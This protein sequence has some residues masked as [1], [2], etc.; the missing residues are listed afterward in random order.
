VSSILILSTISLATTGLP[1]P[2]C[3]LPA[4]E[5]AFGDTVPTTTTPF[6][7]DW[8]FWAFF[9][10]AIAIVLSQMP[11]I[12]QWFRGP[13]LIVEAPDQMRISHGVGYPMSGI[14]LSIR[15]TGGRPARVTSLAFRFRRDG[16]DLIDLPI[17][18][19]H[20]NPTTNDT[21]LLMPFTLQ[22]GV[23]MTHSVNGAFDLARDNSRQLSRLF[24]SVK[25]DVEQKIENA[26]K[27]NQ[28]PVDLVIVDSKLSDEAKVAF[29]RNFIWKAGEYSVEV[30]VKTD[31]NCP[32]R[33]QK[34]QFTL[35]ET[36]EADLRDLVDGYQYGF[37]LG[38]NSEKHAKGVFVKLRRG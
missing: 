38:V 9:V 25:R 2:F 30:V 15:N 7:L 13:L 18:D 16:K 34:L 10:S 19:F 36:D 8:T 20:P 26:R 35:W 4:I 1:G 21:L 6:Y 29:E 3:F 17:T 37:G 23:E 28:Q 32:V 33:Q 31:Q 5:P 14:V 22:P 11:P 12:K 24:S 27:Q